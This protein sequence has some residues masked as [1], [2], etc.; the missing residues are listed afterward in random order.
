MQ[1]YLK[2]QDTYN[3]RLDK[4]PGRYLKE[5]VQRAFLYTYNWILN[6]LLSKLKTFL[7]QEQN[8]Q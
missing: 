2:E 1:A 5:H 8:L 4:Y 3:N 7:L 6:I